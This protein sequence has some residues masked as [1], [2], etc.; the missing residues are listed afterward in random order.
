MAMGKMKR[1]ANLDPKKWS[2]DSYL[3]VKVEAHWSSDVEEY[4]LI[5]DSEYKEAVDRG[6]KN[7]EDDPGLGRGVFTRVDNKD[8]KAAADPYYI[9]FWVRGL[10]G[11]RELLMFT[12]E[13]MDRIRDRVQKNSEDVEANKESWLAD[14]FD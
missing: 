7:P 10:R 9:T 2:S 5:T 14:L 11:S 4:L 6:L 8:K 13:K 12:E 3:F 1:V